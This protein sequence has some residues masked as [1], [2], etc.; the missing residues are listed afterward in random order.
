M[1]EARELVRLAKE[2]CGAEQYHDLNDA[3]AINPALARGSTEIWYMS[4]SFWDVGYR[5]FDNLEK[6]GLLPDPNNLNETHILLG[7]IAAHDL[8]DIFGMMQGEFWSPEGEANSLIRRKGL[9]HTSMSVG[10]VVVVSGQAHYVDSMGFKK[11]PRKVKAKAKTAMNTS[12]TI[13]GQKAE[14]LC[15]IEVL[16]GFEVT[17]AERYYDINVMLT[18]I[19]KRMSW[20]NRVTSAAEAGIRKSFD[21]ALK[22]NKNEFLRELHELTGEVEIGRFSKQEAWS[23]DGYIGV[24]SEKPRLAKGVINLIEKYVP[25][26]GGGVPGTYGYRGS[27]R[28]EGGPKEYS[29]HESSFGIGD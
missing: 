6:K 2:V 10:D 21:A 11:L 3:A 12:H 20:M 19:G 8:E 28:V 13:S 25:T 14:L 22:K 18:S 26:T 1:K 17:S 4:P 7:K 29:Y 16:G 27:G 15:T 5:G 23:D 24:Y 9:Q